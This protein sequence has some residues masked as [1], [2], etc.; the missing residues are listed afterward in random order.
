MSLYR[1]DPLLAF[2]QLIMGLIRQSLHD[3]E[4]STGKSEAWELH[5][6]AF[7]ICSG[8]GV[9]RDRSACGRGG[10]SRTA[11]SESTFYESRII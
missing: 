5:R 3:L 4:R 2:V 11:H 10:L 9:V 1:T 6:R 8:K 7:G